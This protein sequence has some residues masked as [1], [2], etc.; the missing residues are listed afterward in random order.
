MLKE[1]SI[2]SIQFERI[3]GKPVPQW[4]ENL[5]RVNGLA[6]LECDSGE[7]RKG[8]LFVRYGRYCIT[9]RTDFERDRL[10]DVAGVR[11]SIRAWDKRKRAGTD[12][13]MVIDRKSSHSLDNEDERKEGM[14][15]RASIFFKRFN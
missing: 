5:I 15:D 10:S 1:E 2:S 3:S 6:M 9:I 7:R 12:L 14:K 11:F 13:A 8:S 4:V